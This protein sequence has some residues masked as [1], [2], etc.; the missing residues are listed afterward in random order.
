MKPPT[1]YYKKLRSLNPKLFK[2]ITQ[3]EAFAGYHDYV[4]QLS[5]SQMYLSTYTLMR[6]I[7]TFPKWLSTEI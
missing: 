1:I 5:I 2:Y 7:K 4:Y 6:D 3:K